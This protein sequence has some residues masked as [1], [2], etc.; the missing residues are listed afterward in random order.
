MNC[1]TLHT[2]EMKALTQPM[3]LPN[4]KDVLPRVSFDCT[5]NG[6]DLI[7][8]VTHKENLGRK[9]RY[10][11]LFSDGHKD[12]YVPG[13]E[14]EH[15]GFGR[16]RHLDAYEEA[17]YDDLRVVPLMPKGDGYTCVRVHEEGGGDFNVWLRK[18]SEF[19]SAFYN[20]CYQFTLCRL[21]GEWVVSTA[22]EKGYAINLPLARF[23]KDYL[24]EHPF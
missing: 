11:V 19:Y 23:V 18:R 10:H 20:G 4:L 21:S 22:R 2:K 5:V 16:T 7:A 24:N 17:V 3:L 8:T 9:N 6:K 12:A 15:E 13:D 1:L 14:L